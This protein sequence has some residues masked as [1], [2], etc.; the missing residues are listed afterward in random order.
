[1]D[2]VVSPAFQ[3]K[4]VSSTPIRFEYTLQTGHTPFVIYPDG[5]ANAIEAAAQ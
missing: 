5:L 2:Q 4:M 3:A 1:M